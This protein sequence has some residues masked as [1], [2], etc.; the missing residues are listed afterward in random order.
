MN[1]NEVKL[2]CM[3][4]NR[5]SVVGVVTRLQAGERRDSDSSPDRVKQFSSSPRIRTLVR[6]ARPLSQHT[7]GA[8]FAWVKGPGVKLT[9]FL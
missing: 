8:F 3:C 7:P 2:S 5:Y 4:G 9:Y 6:P 1:C